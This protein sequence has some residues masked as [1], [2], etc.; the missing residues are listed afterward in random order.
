MRKILFIVSI[1]LFFSAC[2]VPKSEPEAPNKPTQVPSK[3]FWIGGLDGGVFV[4]VERNENLEANE[5][6]GEIYYVSGDL[7]Y[8]GKLN[9]L[10][11]DSA[12]IDYM[13]PGIYQGWDGDT[14]YVVGNKQL[15]VQE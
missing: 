4:L 12:V 14:L 11:K 3:A 13:N 2:D 9:I 10:P 1:L 8:K 5:Y 15:K 7:A 6:L